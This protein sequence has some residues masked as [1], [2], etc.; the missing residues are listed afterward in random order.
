MS[1]VCLVIRL[2]VFLQLN[3][4]SSLC[5]LDTSPLSDFQLTLSPSLV[6]GLSLDLLTGSLANQK[7][8]FTQKHI[9]KCLSQFY[10]YK[11]PKRETVQM[12][13]NR[14]VLK[15]S[16]FFFFKSFCQASEIYCLL[17]GAEV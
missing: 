3:F 16:G 15:L 14:E 12:F 4:E 17:P 8:M 6:C 5:S 1:S 10:S 11:S 2:F 13:F 9:H 7:F